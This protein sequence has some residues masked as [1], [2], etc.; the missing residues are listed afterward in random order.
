MG[1]GVWTCY[2]DGEKVGLNGIWENASYPSGIRTSTDGCINQG[3]IT[4]TSPHSKKNPL[5]AS[6]HVHR[7]IVCRIIHQPEDF[8]ATITTVRDTVVPSNDPSL[9][10]A[11][12]N[13]LDS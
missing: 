6:K 5:P 7:H 3:L 2:E 1:D 12:V 11:L 13:N 9:P 4:S 10:P 8:F